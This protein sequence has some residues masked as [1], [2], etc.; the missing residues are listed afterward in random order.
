M[1]ALI[2]GSERL[3]ERSDLTDRMRD[4]VLQRG[5]YRMNDFH[6]EAANTIM[7]L[8]SGLNDPPLPSNP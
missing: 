2:D 7:R 1:I 4:G 3:R 5:N 8:V 6:T